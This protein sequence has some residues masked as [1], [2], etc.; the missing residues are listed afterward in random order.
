[1]VFSKVHRRESKRGERMREYAGSVMSLSE[2]GQKGGGGERERGLKRP[3]EL[4]GCSPI[5]HL[6]LRGALQAR[7]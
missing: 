3:N 1:M 4:S 6:F 7:G 2:E 5:L